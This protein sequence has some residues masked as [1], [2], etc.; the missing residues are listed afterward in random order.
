MR[1][2][3]NWSISLFCIIIR[4]PAS[5]SSE[6]C[7]FDR[8]RSNAE[9]LENE[10]LEMIY[11]ADSWSKVKE[12]K[13]ERLRGLLSLHHASL[14]LTDEELR[15]FF[16]T[17]ADDKIGWDRVTNS[18]ATLLHLTAC[19]IKPLITQW[20]LENVPHADMIA[21]D[22]DGYTPLEVLQEKLEKMRTRK[23]Y[24]PFRVTNN[25]IALKETLKLHCPVFHCRLDRTLWGLIKHAFD[26]GVH[27]ATAWEVLFPPE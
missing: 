26:T 5:V 12:L 25:R 23:V 2:S 19:E 24:G 20:L 3:S 10:E 21:R 14:T 15:A 18:E 1:V 13:M 4:S 27:A 16:I 11:E 7:D 6:A 8:R 22:I 17:H 9:D